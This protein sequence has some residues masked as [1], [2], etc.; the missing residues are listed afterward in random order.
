M[1]GGC[2]RSSTFALRSDPVDREPVTTADIEIHGRRI[3][4]VDVPGDT[5]RPAIVL[6]HEGLGSI[7]LWRS[8]PEDL[9]R[10]SGR[11]LVAFSRH[12]HGRSEPPAEPRTPAFF[13]EE[14]LRVLPELRQ[15]LELT[16]PVLVGHSDGASI[17]L[18]HAAHHP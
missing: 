7:D 3:E 18:I 14:A 6:L 12:G 15:Q 13:H 16:D 8:F 11:R 2:A 9:R 10:A 1:S 5:E 17:A 4:V